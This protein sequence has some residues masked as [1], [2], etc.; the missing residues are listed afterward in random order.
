MAQACPPWRAITCPDGGGEPLPLRLQHPRRAH[1]C[2]GPR[3]N[4]LY[5][6]P[7]IAFDS[8]S[9]D[10]D[11]HGNLQLF[12]RFVSR[13]YRHLQRDCERQARAIAKRQSVDSR[14]SNKVT[15]DTSMFRCEAYCLGYRTERG[16]PGILRKH[17]SLHELALNFGK[18]YSAACRF[19]QDRHRK[20]RRSWL[21]TQNRQQNGC[22]QHRLTHFG[23]PCGDRRSI[24]QPAIHPASDVFERTVAH[25]G[26]GAS[27]S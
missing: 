5:E 23:R 13:V 24:R 10:V 4:S 22:I 2:L 12:P 26:C 14:L 8:L 6:P 19:A 16:L 11:R 17:P 3:S 27:K 21:A 9:D 7:Q 15:R 18:V 1:G 25:A 20:S